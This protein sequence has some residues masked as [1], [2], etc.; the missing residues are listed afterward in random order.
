MF[1]LWLFQACQLASSQSKVGDFFISF[2]GLWVL[3]KHI[4][5]LIFCHSCALL[6]TT[7]ASDDFCIGFGGDIQGI[8]YTYPSVKL[9]SCEFARSGKFLEEW[10]SYEKVIKKSQEK[11]QEKAGKYLKICEGN[12]CQSKEIVQYTCEIRHKEL[13]LASTSLSSGR[14]SIYVGLK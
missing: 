7:G 1:S 13:S 2:S 10:W 6:H 9:G 12:V 14:K 3:Y 5:Y 11:N 8:R 4:H